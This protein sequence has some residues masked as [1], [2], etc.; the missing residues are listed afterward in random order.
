MTESELQQYLL[1]HYPKENEITRDL[2][3]K[4]KTNLFCIDIQ[5]DRDCY[6]YKRNKR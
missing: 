5:Q 1:K 4:Y 3:L 6:N 2:P